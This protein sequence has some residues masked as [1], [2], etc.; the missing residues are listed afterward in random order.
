MSKPDIAKLGI[1]CPLENYS[2]DDIATF[3]QQAEKLGYGAI[4]VPEAVGRDPFVT[5]SALALATE[6]IHLA[7]GIANLYARDAMAMKAARNSIDE[8]S[9]G[10]LILGIG[11]SHGD[12]VSGIRQHE[13]GKPLTT[14]RNYLERMEE[15]LYLGPQ[16]AKQGYL[17]LAALREKMLGLAGSKADGAH[18]YFVTPDH[19]AR[20]REILGPENFLAP[21]QKVLLET[22][23]QKA[24]AVSRKAMSMYLA[25]PN[26][27]NN[28]LTLGFTEADF[29]DGGSDRLVD[30]IVA[31]GDEAAIT[32]RLEEHWNNGADHVCIQP[33]RPDG[34]LGFDPA[35][36]EAFAPATNTAMAG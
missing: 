6:E 18:P 36:I 7:T 8:L 1:W 23:P 25:L 4:W 33:L 30:A 14:M 29:E 28:L 5:L 24:R 31:W 15:A 26:Y 22:D 16:P 19:T 27:R 11:V 21:E 3:G 32:Q 13:Y 10:R 35:A 9:G 34:E 20:A 2:F 12:L 17:V